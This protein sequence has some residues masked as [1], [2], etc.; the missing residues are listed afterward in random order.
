MRWKRFLL[1]GLLAFC[2]LTASFAGVSPIVTGTVLDA[3][4]QPIADAQ[5]EISVVS[6]LHAA[7]MR[8]LETL[9]LPAPAAL[10]Q[11]DVQGRFA[12]Q[13][14]ESG[15]YRLLVR[16]PGKVAVEQ[17]VLPLVED[18][19]LAP[20]ELETDLGV[21]ISLVD[22]TG[23][24]IPEARIFTPQ[25]R[26]AP[27]WRLA[28]AEARTDA[29]GRARLPR[30]AG[31]VAPVSI[32]APGFAEIVL[33]DVHSG[34]TLTLAEAQRA[35][36][37]RLRV[38]DA[39]GT[40]VAE[41][42]VRVGE[43][44]WPVVR[45]DAEGHALLDLPK[46][47]PSPIK[48]STADG[49][50][51]ILDL[52]PMT[53]EV[54]IRLPPLAP[55]LAG[56]VRDA[57]SQ[58][59]LA[60]ALVWPAAE[61]GRAVRTDAAGSYQLAASD[62]RN[63][64]AAA[65]GYL[66]G[67]VR[68]GD[69]EIRARRLP[70]LALQ[71]TA[72][73]AGRVVDLAGTPL[74]DVL[75]E[76]IRGTGKNGEPIVAERQRSGADG[77][78]ELRRLAS[79]T[80][81]EL[82]AT[83]PGFLPTIAKASAPSMARELPPLHLVL[84]PAR[85]LIGTVV[86]ERGT[87]LAG[88]RI[89]AR[90]AADPST[91][92]PAT[93]LPAPGVRGNVETTTDSG[94]RFTLAQ[95]PAKQVDLA[96]AHPGFVTRWQ[97][98]LRPPKGVGA[99]NLGKL[100]L[101]PGVTLAGKVVDTRGRPIAGAEIHRVLRI[102]ALE[103]LD[104]TLGDKKPQTTT[105]ADGRFR[106]EDLP[107]GKPVHLF[108]RAEEHLPAAV[109]GLR[110]DA[111]AP[112]VVRLEP[113][114]NLAGFVI[115]ESGA[116]IAD[117]EVHLS[118]RDTRGELPLGPAVY[119][120]TTSDRDGRF[121]LRNARVGEVVLSAS[122]SGFAPWAPRPVSL[123]AGS[124]IEIRLERGDV[125]EGRITDGAGE[126]V[127]G[128]R[129]IAGE[130]A[131]L[132]DAEG[133]YLVAG[134]RPGR[135]KTEFFHPGYR[136]LQ[137]VVTIE[138][139][140]NVLDVVLEAGRR[141]A[142]RVVDENREP[143]SAAEIV[144]EMTERSRSFRLYRASS[145]PAGNFEIASV[146]AGR[147]RLETN[148]QGF[149]PARQEL[150]VAAERDAAP[151]ELVL[152]RGGAIVGQVLGLDPEQLARVEL[153]ADGSGGVAG[154]DSLSGPVDAAGSFE[155][156]DLAAGVWELHA[157]LAS[158]QREVTRRVAVE[159]G[160]TVRRDLEFADRLVL[161][162]RVEVAGEPLSG[163]QIS[164]RA[165]RLALE[166]GAVSG[167]DGSFRLEDLEPDTYWL[168]VSH[169]REMLVHNETLEI[170]SDR[171]VTIRLEAGALEGLVVDAA[172]GEPVATA[173]IQLSPTEGAEFMVAGSTGAEGWFTLPRVPPGRFRLRTVAEG[174][175][176]AEQLVE[177]SAGETPA[178]VEVALEPVPGLELEVRLASGAIPAFVDVRAET[179][180]GVP[181]VWERRPVGADGRVRVST[182]PPGSWHLRLGAAGGGLVEIDV[183]VPGPPVAVV[184]PDA[185][186][187]HVQ[188]PAIIESSLVGT[189]VLLDPAGRPLEVF[190]PSGQ[191]VIASSMIGGQ[192]A[193]A[194]VPAG[195]W[196]VLIETPDGGR[197]STVAVT[198]GRHETR[199]RVE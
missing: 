6:T 142:G 35:R 25:E 192:A 148:A 62:A 97:R 199:V 188:V 37:T 100:A 156:R 47:A 40:P 74:G 15:L 96:A 59:P 164:V 82:R 94:G 163:A 31:A 56:R 18:L 189:V 109:Q 185:A 133:R 10:A 175:S 170:L 11:T 67:G 187:L 195:T 22:A 3:E 46:D 33:D 150:Q 69:A 129:V 24:P 21:E 144:L 51:E 178:S 196:N 155:L 157:V 39:E 136:Q 88:A 186:P 145:D 184:V 93:E 102:A 151:L 78:F 121:V 143:V 182:L 104:L 23:L 68:A 29:Q 190:T 32:L 79:G 65:S 13:A 153:R 92:P 86:D 176:P 166:R 83:R 111:A 177:V 27:G 110:P 120:Q 135:V 81:Y 172:T 26:A 174:Y 179:P 71:R 1:F 147:Y 8:S 99:W 134:V 165:E 113:G 197:W 12:L 63:L 80:L 42:L 107:A 76:A 193:I 16:A 112:L 117:A 87:P 173:A 101:Q 45:T 36:Q 20:V 17:A 50:G 167:Y 5:V 158:E 141:I 60:G 95:L 160:A 180:I 138:P 128:A 154:E 140:R 114:A 70:A 57:E 19:E 54:E 53:S 194:A 169:S 58:R 91:G 7:G 41:A 89:L 108:V 126:P 28:A 137:R 49:R 183:T 168:G 64:Q 106:L 181:P 146:V 198:D 139:G 48:I 105:G 162:G 55:L 43:R 66:R 127:G 159:P 52:D 38:V 191:I 77:R 9:E 72:A 116:P 131:A 4:G 14:P 103:Q 122:A 119:R 123:P 130:A 115:D 2:Q 85:E 125:L 118:W 132:S 161:T 73:L 44:A 61:P 34:L 75:I 149:A 90:E 84:E 152:L 98:N 124:E 171:D 30:R